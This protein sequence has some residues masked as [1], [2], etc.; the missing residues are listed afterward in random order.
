[1]HLK[2]KP[3]QMIKFN[4]TFNES[5]PFQDLQVR[6]SVSVGIF[7]VRLRCV[8]IFFCCFI[9]KYVAETRIKAGKTTRAI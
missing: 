4:K 9:F 1:M 6:L 7:T 5:D 2:Q 8:E 3:K